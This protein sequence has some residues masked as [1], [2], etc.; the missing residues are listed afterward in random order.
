MLST[1]AEVFRDL[2]IFV[3][4]NRRAANRF[5]RSGFEDAHTRAI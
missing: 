4:V 3:G 5:R 1:L 2:L